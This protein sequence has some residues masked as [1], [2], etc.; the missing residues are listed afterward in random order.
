MVGGRYHRG[1]AKLPLK[2]IYTALVLG[3]CVLAGVT[4][5]AEAQR[6]YLTKPT[7]ATAFAVDR[8]NNG[9]LKSLSSVID[10]AQAEVVVVAEEITSGLVLDA[11]QRAAARKL[12]VTVLLDG[13]TNRDPT[14]GALGYL[15]SKQVGSIYV[16]RARI[17]DQVLILDGDTLL[18]SVAPWTPAA[19]K[20]D[21][22]LV[23]LRNAGAGDMMLTYVRE[24]LSTAKQIR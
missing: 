5:S 12:Q 23:L 16:S 8:L 11:L 1:V 3:L 10:R 20:E 9:G 21:G 22:S 18:F 15:L 2:Q 7:R 4:L 13:T 19:A 24:R 6:R 14:S 17:H